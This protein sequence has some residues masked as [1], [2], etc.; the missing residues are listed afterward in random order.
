MSPQP[1]Q[2]RSKWLKVVLGVGI[3][4]A[5]LAVIASKVNIDELIRALTHFQWPYLLSGVACLAAGYA[6]RVLR[7]VLILRATGAAVGFKGCL[8]PF[9]GAI[10]LN[11]V[12]PFRMGDVVRA[13]VFPVS[14]GIRKTVAATSLVVERLIDLLTLLV[15]LVAGLF[16]IRSLEIPVAIKDF[17]VTL[18][19]LGGGAFVAGV[20]LSGMLARYV[21]SYSTR[22]S[23]AKLH[24]LLLVIAELLKSFEQMSRPKVT[25]S[26]LLVSVFVWIAESGLFYFVLLG[27]G[28]QA[29]M[30]T[31]LLVMSLAT[32]S[33]LVPSSPGYVGPFHL[34]TFT[35]I[36]LVGGDMALAGSYAILVHLA[37]WVSTTAAGA[38]SI[39][40]R[41]DLFRMARAASL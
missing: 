24:K 9:L 41:P 15:C 33:T 10:A 4:V 25:A 30:L 37:L 2:K 21:E 1:N 19:I 23:N 27:F 6:F 38:V 12:L 17:A 14:M 32:L 39:A 11:N 5:C 28:F 13:L 7:W 31:A 26:L 20:L 40:L 36:S 8:A 16:A 3:S 34:A 29:G 22:V 18:A 35:A